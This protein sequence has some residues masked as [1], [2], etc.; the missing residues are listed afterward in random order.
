MAVTLVIAAPHLYADDKPAGDG[1]RVVQVNV[2]GKTMPIKVRDSKD[3]FRNVSSSQSSGKYDPERIFS[4]TSSMADKK[5]TMPTETATRSDSSQNRPA[6]VTK[7]FAE[8]GFLTAPNLHAKADARTSSFNKTATGFDRSYYTAANDDH[9]RQAIPGVTETSP[10][11]HR[12]AVLGGPE[13]QDALPTD[14]MANKQYL[15]PGAQHVPS[16]VFIKENVVL[17][18]VNDLPNRPLTI[19]EV[20]NLINHETKPNTDAK[21]DAPSKALN[22]PNYKPEPLRDLSLIKDEDK[23]D[24]VPPPGMM[25]RPPEN[26]EPLPQ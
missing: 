2:G 7:P 20:R 18:R 13:K 23:D 5:F 17:T 26:S 15:G 10:D 12:T 6:F 4:T 9:A 21:P 14:S 8:D 22:D 3:P 25:S 1:D 16:N 11:Q 19:D 24:S